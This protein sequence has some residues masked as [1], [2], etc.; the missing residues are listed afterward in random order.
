MALVELPVLF[1]RGAVRRCGIAETLWF[2]KR[3]LPTRNMCPGTTSR[4]TGSKLPSGTRTVQVN[5]RQQELKARL[6]R[7]MRGADCHGLGPQ[8]TRH[9]R[10]A[11]RAPARDSRKKILAGNASKSASTTMNLPESHR[12]RRMADPVVRR[13]PHLIDA[14][15]WAMIVFSEAARSAA[16]SHRPRERGSQKPSGLTS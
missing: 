11:A 15:R 5:T 7:A 8:R 13:L 1:R 10:Q 6:W 2:A 3:N 16:V 12:K 4:S 9:G 14:L